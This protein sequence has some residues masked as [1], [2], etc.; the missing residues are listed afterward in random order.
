MTSLRSLQMH[1]RLI[2]RRPIA[3]SQRILRESSVWL[4]LAFCR[5]LRLHPDKGGDPEL[6]KEVTHALVAL[7]FVYYSYILIHLLGT[8][9]SLTQTREA[10][11]M[12]GG[13][14]VYLSKA[15]WVEWIHRCVA[16]YIPH[17]F[18]AGHQ[19][20]HSGS[21][22]PIIWRWRW[23]LW[24]GWGGSST[25]PPPD[26]GSGPS[27]TRHPWRPLQRKDHQAGINEKRHLFQMQRE[28][29]Q[30]RCCAVMQ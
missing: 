1:Q 30:G 9:F 27:G 6:F 18:V 24:W 2:S 5:A 17:I 14:P 11:M 3:K 10:Y 29:W 7:P 21:L 12:L 16:K 23:V 13:R 22:Q 4:T 26:Q 25:G 8:K 28:R 15:E 19:P 20:I